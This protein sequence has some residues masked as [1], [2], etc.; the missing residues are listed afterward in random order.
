MRVLS[1]PTVAASLTLFGLLSGVQAQDV[2]Y[3]TRRIELVVPFP[4]GGTTDV[5]ARLAAQIVFGGGRKQRRIPPPTPG[6]HPVVAK[7]VRFL[8]PAHQNAWLPRELLVQRGGSTLH[9]ADH[10]KVWSMDHH[11]DDHPARDL[12]F[13]QLRASY[14]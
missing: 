12:L 4:A 1:I 6:V 2:N 7:K 10:D 3:P 14:S 11:P 8:G 9:G 5:I 13:T